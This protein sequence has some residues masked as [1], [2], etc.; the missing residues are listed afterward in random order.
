[1]TQHGD[2][3]RH[4]L[5]PFMAVVIEVYDKYAKQLGPTPWAVY[6]ALCRYASWSG[7]RTCFPGQDR[8]AE[9]L[10]I[11]RTT[12]WRAMKR[13]EK[14]GLVII[15][16]DEDPDTK[17]PRRANGTW[18]NNVYLLPVV[19]VPAT[20]A[21]ADEVQDS[22]NE[23]NVSPQR[24]MAANDHIAPMQSPVAPAQQPIHVAPTQHGA[25][26]SHVAAMQH[27]PGTSTL[28]TNNMDHVAICNTNESHTSN[29]K[30]DQTR[31]PARPTRASSKV[32][33][34]VALQA[35]GAPAATRIEHTVTR[36]DD[37][38]REV[39][40]LLPADWQPDEGL[41]AWWES[42]LAEQRDAAALR[43]L[44]DLA[45]ENE[46]FHYRYRIQPNPE[47][48]EPYLA[49]SW[50]ATWKAF[51]RQR[52]TW[53]R[54]D[55]AKR[56]GVQ[57]SPPPA[58]PFVPT[59]PGARDERPLPPEESFTPDPLELAII[60]LQNA[61]AKYH[62]RLRDEH[63]E[64]LRRVAERDVGKGGIDRRVSVAARAAT[65]LGDVLTYLEMGIA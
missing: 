25:Q 18:L 27:G 1:M 59:E 10:S 24:N 28:Q 6:T 56:A 13:L 12:V 51:M 54:K 37:V 52:I 62:E 65:S 42:L 58:R 23:T 44:I 61:A 33:A 45:I 3:V 57:T 2:T 19:P 36:T 50:A 35:P 60:Q 5:P 17:R 55:L 29:E 39:L 41:L 30:H 22:E 43:S 40:T 46:Q 7:E 16:P 9:D 32:Q 20:A 64:R 8:I 38:P 26:N 14:L 53:T 11:D 15:N 63:R 47:T 4:G 48:K 34:T 21:G 49:H 31:R